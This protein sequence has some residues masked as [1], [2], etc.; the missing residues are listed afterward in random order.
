MNY[1]ACNADDEAE[2]KIIKSRG[3]SKGGQRLVALWVYATLPN[4][5]THLHSHSH[6]ADEL[7]EHVLVCS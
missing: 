6:I 3:I 7:D 4:T 1:N 5:H 2:Y